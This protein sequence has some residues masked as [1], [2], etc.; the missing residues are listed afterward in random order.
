MDAISRGVSP[1][2]GRTGP[3]GGYELAGPLDSQA[4]TG[5][6]AQKS[7]REGAL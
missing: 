1:V 5:C 7:A 3:R 2:R 6:G 4:V